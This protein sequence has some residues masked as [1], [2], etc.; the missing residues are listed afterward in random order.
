MSNMFTGAGA[1]DQNLGSWYIVLD[2]DA[3]NYDDAPG[4]VG[5]ITAQNSF[6]DGQNPVYGI[7]T[8]GTLTHLSWTAPTWC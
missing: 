4:T 2:D 8:G 7:G 6:L 1:F 3:I 5:S